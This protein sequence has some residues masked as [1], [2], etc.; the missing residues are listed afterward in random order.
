MRGDFKTDMTIQQGKP[1]FDAVLQ[2]FGDY[3]G[4]RFVIVVGKEPGGVWK[5]TGV[6]TPSYRGNGLFFPLQKKRD[7]GK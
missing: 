4:V 7:C 1:D 2:R 5:T 6:N 3:P